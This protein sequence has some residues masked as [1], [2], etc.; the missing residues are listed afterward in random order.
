MI[1]KNALSLIPVLM[2]LSACVT[3][4]MQETQPANTHPVVRGQAQANSAVASLL[5]DA[6]SALRAGESDRAA[7]YLERALRLE[8]KNPYVWHQLAEVRLYEG[9]L[10]QARQLA[11]RSNALAGYDARLRQANKSLIERSYAPPR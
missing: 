11:A 7:A 8:P 4:P 6:R 9:K 1:K 3:P 10:L 5:V 2:V